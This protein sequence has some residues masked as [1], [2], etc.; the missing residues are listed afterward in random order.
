MAAKSK[1]SA[2]KKKKG[3]IDKVKGVWG[4]QIMLIFWFVCYLIGSPIDVEKSFMLES[5]LGVVCFV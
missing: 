2:K 1:G 4:G 3:A 5:P